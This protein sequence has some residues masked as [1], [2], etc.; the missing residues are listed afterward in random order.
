MVVR[1]TKTNGSGQTVLKVDGLLQSMDV[2]SLHREWATIAG[3]AA[4][5]LSELRS[6]DSSGVDAIHRLKA[7]GAELRGVSPYLELLLST[8]RATVIGEDALPW[9]Q[10]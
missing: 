7:E 9:K 1:I 3:P 4:L 10:R 2:D 6:A 8:S 5:E